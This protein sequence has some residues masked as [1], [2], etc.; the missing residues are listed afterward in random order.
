[1]LSL[2]ILPSLSETPPKLLHHILPLQD[3]YTN[4]NHL[5]IQLDPNRPP[6]PQILD[7]ACLSIDAFCKA[8]ATVTS[9]ELTQLKVMRD[10]RFGDQTDAFNVDPIFDFCG[11]RIHTDTDTVKREG[12]F[13][14]VSGIIS[15]L[16]LSVRVSDFI[17]M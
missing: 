12:R 3:E 2:P 14:D 11:V 6:A 17:Y 9:N 5:S 16:I 7:T 13:S 10:E 15:T 1:M 8:F 4:T